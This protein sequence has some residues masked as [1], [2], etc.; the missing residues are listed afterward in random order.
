MTKQIE[1]TVNSNKFTIQLYD[2][3]IADF[4]SKC[5]YHLQHLDFTNNFY[6]NP[7]NDIR[8]NSDELDSQLVDIATQLGISIEKNKLKSQQYLNYLHSLFEK[9]YDGKN[10]VWLSYHESIHIRERLNDDLF[11]SEYFRIDFRQKAGR[12]HKPFDRNFLEYGQTTIN[13]GQCYLIWCELGKTPYVYF[14]DGEPDN[15]QR[16]CELAKPWLELKPILHISLQDKNFY[17]R[18]KKEVE[19]EQWF[20][21]YKS[22]WCRHWNISNWS[23]KEMFSVIPVGEIDNIDL[24]DKTLQNKV[25]YIKVA[26]KE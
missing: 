8:Y 17:K 12:L 10:A 20:E 16:L 22:D 13:R 24:F 11:Q 5:Y 26:L 1:L 9:G 7:Y 18:Y 25:T 21:K 2:N 19:F 6:D 4:V 14:R 15:L 3:P 23:V